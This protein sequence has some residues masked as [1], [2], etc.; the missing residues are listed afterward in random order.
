MRSIGRLQYRDLRRLEYQFNP[1]EEPMVMVRKHAVI[2]S[3]TP[4][5]AIV[6]A[7]RLLFVVPNGADSLLRMLENHMRD[8]APRNQ[9][10][11]TRS[12]LRSAT[13]RPSENAVSGVTPL[14]MSMS[15]N[16]S[17]PSPMDLASAGTTTPPLPEPSPLPT[18]HSIPVVDGQFESQCYEALLATIIA[19]QTRELDKLSIEVGKVLFYFRNRSIMSLAIQEQMRLLKSQIQELCSK[20]NANKR[21]LVELLEDSMELTYMNVSATKMNPLLYA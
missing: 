17:I 3:F 16:V 8:W 20:I 6:L 21:K 14:A 7:D 2:F 13:G 9:G 10:Q 4:L 15:S 11:T 1:H 18:D 5:R 12:S 19:L